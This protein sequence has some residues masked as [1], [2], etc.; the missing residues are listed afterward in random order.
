MR[1]ASLIKPKSNFHRL[2]TMLHLNGGSLYPAQ[3]YA[4]R[5]SKPDN[6]TYIDTG[7]MRKMSCVSAFSPLS[8]AYEHRAEDMGLVTIQRHK[9]R[10][11]VVL[12]PKG[13]DVLLNVLDWGH[14]WDYKD[15]KV[16]NKA[17]V[18]APAV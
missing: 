1:G 10:K 3:L 6:H 9:N 7:G 12:L 16:T 18:K 14:A 8:Y 5:G 17:W 2:L 13:R 4:A 11:W 15:S